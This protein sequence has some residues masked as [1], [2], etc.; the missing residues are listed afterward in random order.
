MALRAAQCLHLTSDV[1]GCGWALKWYNDPSSASDYWVH[2]PSQLSQSIT[3]QHNTIFI[4]KGR[5]QHF[6]I[7][8]RSGIKYF[9]EP[10]PPAQ[11]VLC[12]R[13]WRRVLSV[14]ALSD[15]QGYIHSRWGLQPPRLSEENENLWTVNCPPPLHSCLGWKGNRL[16]WPLADFH[17]LLSLYSMSRYYN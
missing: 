4:H 17:T 3:T 15:D 7:S 2:W 1:P 6:N 16:Q 10:A 13:S 11:S 12:N 8:S 14:K 5:H 9:L